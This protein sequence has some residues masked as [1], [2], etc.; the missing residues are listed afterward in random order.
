MSQIAVDRPK[1]SL[2]GK[3]AP[4]ALAAYKAKLKI[5]APPAL[6]LEPTAKSEAAIV[7]NPHSRTTPASFVLIT[8]EPAPPHPRDA[9]PRTAAQRKEEI[10]RWIV[11]VGLAVRRSF[12]A[13]SLEGKA[14]FKFVKSHRLSIANAFQ[15]R[16]KRDDVVAELLR[17][18]QTEIQSTTEVSG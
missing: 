17:M 8:G 15:R 12:P 1:L 16:I 18:Y 7:A 4:P 5:A 13:G 6:P 11:G 14:A 9:E 10:D 3:R 2:G